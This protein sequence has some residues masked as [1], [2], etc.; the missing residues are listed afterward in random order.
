MAEN[1]PHPFVIVGASLAGATAATALREEGFDGPIVLV[2]DEREHPY[3][4]PPLSKGY[5][6][7][8]S[9]KHE[10][11]VHPEKWY[12]EHD[13]ELVLGTSVTGIDRS[14]HQVVLSDGRRLDYAKLLLTTG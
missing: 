12:S 11:F 5:L 4:R 1:E 14:E 10:I 6:Q 13:V 2:G 9:E 7:G 3:E 8:K